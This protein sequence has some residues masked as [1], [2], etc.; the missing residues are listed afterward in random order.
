MRA[1]RD[2][3]EALGTPFYAPESRVPGQP[4]PALIPGGVYVKY[5]SRTGLC[6][7]TAYSGRDRGV[8]V[9]L[10]QK[11]VGHFPLGLFD[12]GMEKEA[13]KITGPPPPPA[14]N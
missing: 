9:Q 11:Q 13:P 14:A 2:Y 10:A 7:V 5:N 4:H 12:E 3:T 6:Y 1:L 8:L